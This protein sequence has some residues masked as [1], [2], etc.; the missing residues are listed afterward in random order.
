MGS[1]YSSFLLYNQT[2]RMASWKKASLKM[3]EVKM[4]AGKW[5]NLKLRE[6]RLKNTIASQTKK[7]HIAR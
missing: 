2:G 3:M 1:V 5:Q 4:L 6:R 7:S